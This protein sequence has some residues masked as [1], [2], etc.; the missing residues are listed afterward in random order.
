VREQ[1]YK[2]VLTGEGADEV[3]GGY[4]LFKEA[5]VRRFWARQPG[6]RLRPTPAG[7]LY[8]YLQN[9]PVSN[10]AFAAILLRPGHG[11]PRTAIFAHVPRWTTSQRALNFLSPELRA[12][13][14]SWDALDWYE[15][16]LAV[17]T[18]CAGAPL[19]RDQYVE[20]K[21]LLAGYLLSSQGDRVAMA[22]SIEGRFPYLDHRVIEFANRLPPS[23]KIRGLTE[24]Y[25]LRRALAGCCPPTSSPAPS[26]PTA[27]RTARVSSSTASRWTTW[28][29]A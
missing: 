13:V 18:S 26:S 12:S 24:K 3:F 21:S 15:Q 17:R 9:S 16:T 29:P 20:A 5:K 10:P 8:G 25:L 2:V 27:R 23:F 19:A 28:R 6:S 22:N 11:T 7:R 4:D 1:G 14:G